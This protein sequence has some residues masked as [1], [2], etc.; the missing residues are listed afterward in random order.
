MREGGKGERRDVER[1]KHD[2]V[3]RRLQ[4]MKYRLSRCTGPHDP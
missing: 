2:T 1:K 3:K 4:A